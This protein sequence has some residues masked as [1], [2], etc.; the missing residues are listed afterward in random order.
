[1][2]Y[3]FVSI[4]LRGENILLFLVET[5]GRQ[6]LEQKQY[7][8]ARSRTTSSSA[9]RKPA[10]IGKINHLIIAFMKIIG[11]LCI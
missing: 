2:L 3:K 8:A 11:D 9:P 7:R 4:F 5:A 10:D 6:M 1:M